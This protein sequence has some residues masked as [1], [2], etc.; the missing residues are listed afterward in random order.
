MCF[1]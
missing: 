1:K